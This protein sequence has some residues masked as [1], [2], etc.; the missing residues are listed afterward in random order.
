MQ[1]VTADLLQPESLAGVCEG[2]SC[3]LAPVRGNAPGMT[4]A[5]Q[6]IQPLA[7]SLLGRVLWR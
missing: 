3:V 6:A 1:V 7:S 2:V 5:M 4:V